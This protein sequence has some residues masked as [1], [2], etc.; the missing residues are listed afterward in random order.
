MGHL[1]AIRNL[2]PPGFELIQKFGM[3]VKQPEKMDYRREWL[4][5]APLVAGER[6][7]PA[8]GQRRRLPLGQLQLST[9]TT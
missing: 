7:V 2:P 9:D 8:A 6:V 5:F 3:P 4:R 1:S